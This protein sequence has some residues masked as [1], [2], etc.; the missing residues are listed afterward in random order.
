MDCPVCGNVFSNI[1]IRYSRRLCLRCSNIKH[2]MRSVSKDDEDI[3]G[4]VG[5]I[6]NCQ[7][8]ITKYLHETNNYDKVQQDAERS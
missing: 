3:H 4:D 2:A 5:S 1:D 6:R 7:N 8:M